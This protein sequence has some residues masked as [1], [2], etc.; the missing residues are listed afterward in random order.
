MQM[1]H[2]LIYNMDQR[3]KE[4][5]N[6]IQYCLKRLRDIKKLVSC[7]VHIE[8]VRTRENTLFLDQT[9]RNK[10]SRERR[11]GGQH[12]SGLCSV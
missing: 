1:D 8:T 3:L 9:R 5:I 10:G 4:Y 11:R 6:C 7:V 2:Q 12:N